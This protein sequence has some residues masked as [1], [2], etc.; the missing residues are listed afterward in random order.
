MTSRVLSLLLIVATLLC[1]F[2][3]GRV[4]ASCCAAE[5]VTDCKAP[6][7]AEQCHCCHSE[8]AEAGGDVLPEMITQEHDQCP[9]ACPH[10]DNGSCQ[11][12]CG[13]AVYS[14]PLA[15]VCLLDWALLP[16]YTVNLTDP[17]GVTEWNPVSCWFDR[18]SGLAI[19]LLH[20]SF[21]C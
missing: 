5:E 18:G 11:G 13:G 12:V 2:G 17:P 1:P 3:C 20:M 7:V 9:P 10:N 4:F 14:G 19:R 6:A 8:M 21:L 16:S 15:S